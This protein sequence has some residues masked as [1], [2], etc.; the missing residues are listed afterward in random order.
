MK[1]HIK[2]KSVSAPF[3]KNIVKNYYLNKFNKKKMYNKNSTWK[4]LLN[5][6]HGKKKKL[7]KFLSEEMK[8]WMNSQLPAKKDK[9]KIKKLNKNLKI[10]LRYQEKFY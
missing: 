1:I 10:Q 6:M 5:Q 7:L 4:Q 9:V 2:K 8:N 3:Y